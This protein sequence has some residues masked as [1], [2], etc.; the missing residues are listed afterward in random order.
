MSSRVRT[1]GRPDADPLALLDEGHQRP[2]YLVDALT[3]LGVGP[4]N[5]LMWD[6]QGLTIGKPLDASVE[7]LPDRV[8]EQCL[9]GHAPGVTCRCVHPGFV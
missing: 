7:H 2:R 4:P 8:A 1:I 5:A 3:E 6:H 9:I